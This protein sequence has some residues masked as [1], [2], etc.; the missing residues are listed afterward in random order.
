MPE[1]SFQTLTSADLAA[2]ASG[3]LGGTAVVAALRAGQFGKHKLLI[4]GLVRVGGKVVS[5]AAAMLRDNYDL[6]AS[7]ER[8]APEAVAEVLSSPHVA[9]WAARCLR[10]LTAEPEVIRADMDHFAAVVAAAAIR[11]GHACTVS[12]WPVDGTV[13][14]PTLGRALLPGCTDAK[15]SVTGP[16]RATVCGTDVTVEIDASAEDDTAAWQSLR[17]LDFGSRRIPLD[18]LDPYRDYGY[19]ELAGRLTV[20]EFS[21]WRRCLDDARQ[22]LGQH[23]PEYAA[24]LEIGVTALVPIS[25]RSGQKNFSATSGDAFAA[26]ATSW[27][28]DGAALAL[29]LIHEFQHAKLCAVTDLEPLFH[30]Q[31]DRLFY[32]PWRPDPRPGPALFHGVFAHMGVADFWRV[33]RHIATGRA[34]LVAEVEFTRWLRQTVDAADQLDGYDG[35]TPAGQ[36]L[37]THVTTRLRSWLDEPVTAGAQDHAT[38]A[39]A[40][41]LLCWRLRNLVPD[42]AA[43]AAAAA[44]WRSGQPAPTAIPVL[45]SPPDDHSGRT[46][47]SDLLYEKLCAQDSSDASLGVN[48]GDPDLA[49]V[50]GDRVAATQGYLKEIG[51]AA[52]SQHAWGGLALLSDPG[53]ALRRCPEIVSAVYQETVRM[54]GEPVDPRHVAEWLAPVAAFTDVV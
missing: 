4:R 40:D 11:A 45:L 39:A 21:H 38:T 18:D 37:L 12:V 53:N 44:A 26:V 31:Q 15:L 20:T 9:A 46:A 24:A 8:Q 33:Y 25:L 35:L 36:L 34:R 29:A 16:M 10:R 32:A 1:E 50:R 3:G 19:C 30:R 28:S 51:V 52:G 47:R 42:P 13:M 7:I 49:Y 14:L 5:E 22:L 43:A 41:H 2:L 54:S 17:W 6:L 23:F 48:A 27:P